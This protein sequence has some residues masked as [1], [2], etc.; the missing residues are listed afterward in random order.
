[1]NASVPS[2]EDLAARI[3]LSVQYLP[4]SSL[5]KYPTIQEHTQKLKYA[6]LPKAS[7]RSASQIPF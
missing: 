6:K 2:G 3:N 7:A 5:T 4:L 1:M